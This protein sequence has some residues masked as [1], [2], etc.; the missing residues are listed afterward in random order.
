MELWRE[1]AL[2]VGRNRADLVRRVDADLEKHA[3]LCRPEAGASSQGEGIVKCNYFDNGKSLG[4]MLF[5]NTSLLNHSC[6]PNASVK[7]LISE[8][9]ACYSRVKVTRP[10]AAG[11]QV[12]ITYSQAK[13]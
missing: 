6:H 2:T 1:K 4:A 12:L 10:I 8:F 5:E 11:E 3:A 7:M 9:G 13:L